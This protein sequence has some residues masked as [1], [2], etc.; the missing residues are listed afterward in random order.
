MSIGS[1]WT[2]EDTQINGASEEAIYILDNELSP[3]DHIVP[4]VGGLCGI[5][6]VTSAEKNCVPSRG[7]RARADS[8]GVGERLVIVF[9]IVPSRSGADEDVVVVSS[10][11]GPGDRTSCITDGHVVSAARISG[12]GPG[13]GR[14]TDRDVERARRVCRAGLFAEEGV[15]FAARVR[16]AAK[17]AEER[18]AGRILALTSRMRPEEG[19][20]SAV[21]V[22]FAGLEAEEGIAIA[23]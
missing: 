2:V 3:D 1:R 11:I 9:L 19:V 8:C 18:V 13:A 21:Y 16:L 22:R 4:T 7:Y 10:L 23:A 5:T 12:E 20:G 6:Q 17:V 14:I 15:E